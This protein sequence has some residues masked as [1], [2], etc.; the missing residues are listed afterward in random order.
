MTIRNT[1][2]VGRGSEYT[3]PQKWRD[4]M[5]ATDAQV[6]IIMR[7]EAKEEL[8]SKPLRKPT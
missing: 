8:K 2:P 5:T 7:K 4:R 6:R 3:V 1:H